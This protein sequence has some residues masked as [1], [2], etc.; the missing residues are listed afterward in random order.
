MVLISVNRQPMGQ[1]HCI[2]F[3]LM[4]KGAGRVTSSG[5]QNGAGNADNISPTADAPSFATRGSLLFVH[6]HVIPESPRVSI[7]A[8]NVRTEARWVLIKS[9]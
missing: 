8:C 2:D 5:A 7:G 6:A 4:I 9:E 3:F 1:T